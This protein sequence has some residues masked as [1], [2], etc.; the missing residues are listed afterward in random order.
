[1]EDCDQLLTVLRNDAAAQDWD[2]TCARL[3]A[4]FEKMPADAKASLVAGD[5]C[6]QALLHAIEREVSSGGDYWADAPLRGACEA[7]NALI[8]GLPKGVKQALLSGEKGVVDAL[9]RVLSDAR[10]KSAWGSVGFSFRNMFLD[11]TADVRQQLLSDGRGIVE[12]IVGVLDSDE[13]AAWAG[14]CGALHG[15]L[16]NLSASTKQSLLSDEKGVVRGLLRVLGDFGA[17]P[18]QCNSAAVSRR[19]CGGGGGGERYQVPLVQS[20]GDLVPE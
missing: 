7:L 14:A 20:F 9:L 12:A 17:A 3:K 1:M 13:A 10:G 6:V 5:D 18:P 16:G 2:G 4:V 11:V 8:T 19:R 15:F